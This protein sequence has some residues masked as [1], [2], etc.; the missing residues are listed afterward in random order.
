MKISASKE[1][2]EH[3]PDPTVNATQELY[4]SDALK[5]KL[6]NRFDCYYQCYI[7]R[8]L[9]YFVIKTNKKIHQTYKWNYQH[10]PT[11]NWEHLASEW[12]IRNTQIRNKNWKEEKPKWTVNLFYDF[13][14]ESKCRISFWNNEMCFKSVD[15]M[16]RHFTLHRQKIF[17]V[18]KVVVFGSA[19][20]SSIT[21]IY[22]C[23]I[24]LQ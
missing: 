14:L 3:Q 18:S 24:I 22:K 21:L 11:V 5:E 9:K 12:E 1:Q 20:F 15:G 4:D 10:S 16:R 13:S 2:N 6:K 19:M 7:E 8:E 17:I 23:V